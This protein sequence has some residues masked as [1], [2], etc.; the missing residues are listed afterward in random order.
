[1]RKFGFMFMVGAA[2]LAAGLTAAQ[3]KP[4]PVKI[5]KTRSD[6]REVS[7][8]TTGCEVVGVGPPGPIY[9]PTPIP[10]PEACHRGIFV[11]ELLGFQV[12]APRAVPVYVSGELDAKGSSRM[13][14]K[15]ILFVDGVRV[16]R[17]PLLFTKAE[18]RYAHLQITGTSELSKGAHR[19]E[20]SIRPAEEEGLVGMTRRFLKLTVSTERPS[21]HVER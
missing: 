7:Y 1:M 20:L 3:G 14:A 10:V 17:K 4:R 21:G 9:G 11:S 6:N 16:A 2:V 19:V 13:R 12:V 8:A 5:N 18:G 15:V